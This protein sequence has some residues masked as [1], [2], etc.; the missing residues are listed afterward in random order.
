MISPTS[1]AKKVF[2]PTNIE[3]LKEAL[4]FK[5]LY[6]NG[7]WRQWKHV[8][9]ETAP[10]FLM[11]AYVQDPTL[12]ED[13]SGQGCR[14]DASQ[15][16]WSTAHTEYL[17]ESGNA[18]GQRGFYRNE[19][20]AALAGGFEPR[21]LYELELGKGIHRRLGQHSNYQ[22]P[23]EEEDMLYRVLYNGRRRR[24]RPDYED[25]ETEE[26][27]SEIVSMITQVGRTIF[28]R[29]ADARE[30]HIQ[31]TI[32]TVF[33]G[34]FRNDLSCPSDPTS[35]PLQQDRVAMNCGAKF[36][37]TQ[38]GLC[39]ELIEQLEEAFMVPRREDGPRDPIEAARRATEN[40]LQSG[41]PSTIHVVEPELS[42]A[43]GLTL[44][45]AASISTSNLPQSMTNLSIGGDQSV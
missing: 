35:I 21:W 26:L 40:I 34:S 28:D 41:D 27:V 13:P 17:E 11:D 4:Q 37:K 1:I 5:F 3:S 33:G 10:L 30:A 43:M 7:I 31:D 15:A 44:G 32:S 12:F 2:D 20:L 25:P 22:E 18:R 29:D 36:L 39:D 23:M 16:R 8:Y 38:P 45:T 14:E 9:R 42:F 19:I 6:V 24:R